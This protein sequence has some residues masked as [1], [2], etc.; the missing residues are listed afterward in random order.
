MHP[1]IRPEAAHPEPQREGTAAARLPWVGLGANGTGAGGFD[2]SWLSDL[3]SAIWI[4]SSLAL[5]SMIRA[6]WRELAVAVADLWR[7]PKYLKRVRDSLTNA[8]TASQ[9]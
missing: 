3:S 2:R 5:W 7:G 6:L 9:R 8:K 1:N 4:L